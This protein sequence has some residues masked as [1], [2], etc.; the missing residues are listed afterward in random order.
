MESY[1]KVHL[2]RPRYLRYVTSFVVVVVCVRVCVGG[3]ACVCV[4]V[5]ER[6]RYGCVWK[7]EV[8]EERKEGWRITNWCIHSNGKVLICELP[9]SSVCSNEVIPRTVVASCQNTIPH[10]LLKAGA[11]SDAVDHAIEGSRHTCSGEEPKYSRYN[12]HVVASTAHLF[13]PFS[14]LL[15]LL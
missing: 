13:S 6:E 2:I 10:S 14:S 4:C 12:V 11:V 5:R 9:S 3:C 1:S 7:E 15:M 8:V